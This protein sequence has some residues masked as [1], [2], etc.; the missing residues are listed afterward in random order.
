[1]TEWKI[2]TL[3]KNRKEKTKLKFRNCCCVLWN[4]RRACAKTW[5][6]CD[7][8]FASFLSM[9]SKQNDD[10]FIAEF[11]YWN[12]A[13]CAHH[14]AAAATTTTIVTTTTSMSVAFESHSIAFDS[15]FACPL[16]ML[17]CSVKQIICVNRGKDKTKKTKNNRKLRSCIIEE[18][19]CST[20]LNASD[21]TTLIAKTLNGNMLHHHS[22]C[23]LRSG[24]SQSQTH[25]PH[26]GWL[27]INVQNVVQNDMEFD[28]IFVDKK[29]DDGFAVVP[30]SQKITLQA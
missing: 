26:N 6:H 2:V 23:H 21:G 28:C 12:L 1:M 15:A 5:R 20:V 14:I 7:D 10:H 9:K 11:Q 16:A 19:P 13:L 4:R 22:S 25:T 3:K 30:H 24:H 8:A 18:P 29:M 27:S 17:V